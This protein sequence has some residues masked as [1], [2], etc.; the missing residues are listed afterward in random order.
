[1]EGKTM[2]INEKAKDTTENT[3]NQFCDET[4]RWLAGHL[5]ADASGIEAIFNESNARLFLFI[6]PVFEKEVFDRSVKLGK[7]ESKTS[8]YLVSLD[9][10]ELEDITKR[11]YRRYFNCSYYYNNLINPD[12]KKYNKIIDGILRKG[13]NAIEPHEKLYFLFFVTY[14]YRNNI[15]H[16]N[17]D[18]LNWDNNEEQIRDCI[19]FMIK[20]IETNNL[21][22]NS[23]TPQ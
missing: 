4:I 14:R 23:K 1:M 2:E 11:F 21:I 8:D 6:W 15:F 10:S 19:T 9:I 20:I 16:G 22:K 18:I 13:Y 3:E 5:G 17:K 7:I 12:E